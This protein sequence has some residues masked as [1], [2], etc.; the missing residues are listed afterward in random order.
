V[1]D[2]R[3]SFWR[4]LEALGEEEVRKRLAAHQFGATKARSASQWLVYR[5]S[6][7]SSASNAQSLAF[8]R[9][10]NDLAR[11]ANAVASEANAIARDSASSARLSAKAARNSNIIATVALIAAVISIALSIIAMLWKG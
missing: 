9:E 10:A 5:E 2:P 11:S 7:S 4:E 8:A 1:S 3:D 6:L